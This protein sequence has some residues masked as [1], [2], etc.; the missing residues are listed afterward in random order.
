MGGTWASPRPRT[1]PAG[2]AVSAWK[3]IEKHAP[4]QPGAL[5]LAQQ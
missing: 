2:R 5:K 3:V 4:N 1:L